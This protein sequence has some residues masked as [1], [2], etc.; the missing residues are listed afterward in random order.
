MLKSGWYFEM[1]DLIESGY[2]QLAEDSR[3]LANIIKNKKISSK[4]INIDYLFKSDAL[5]NINSKINDL[6]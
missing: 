6:L 5:K 1:N 4:K 2:I 3:D